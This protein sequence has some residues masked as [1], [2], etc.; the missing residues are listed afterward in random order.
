MRASYD[1]FVDF[2]KMGH[3]FSK[4]TTGNV[5]KPVVTTGNVHKPKKHH[6]GK[7][8]Q[9]GE[10]KLVPP[11]EQGLLRTKLFFVI[12]NHPPLTTPQP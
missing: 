3:Y 8:D 6:N 11:L 12:Y 7:R 9:T 5:Y 10:V 1:R 4:V 2:P